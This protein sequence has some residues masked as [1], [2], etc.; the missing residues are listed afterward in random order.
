M[1]GHRHS[2][3]D[4]RQLSRPVAAQLVAF[5]STAINLGAFS[6]QSGAA[7]LIYYIICDRHILFSYPLQEFLIS[8]HPVPSPAGGSS[9]PKNA[10]V[11]PSPLSLEL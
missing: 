11:H 10:V 6:L 4:G 9:S 1:C 3:T 2:Y 7:P 8:F 5:A